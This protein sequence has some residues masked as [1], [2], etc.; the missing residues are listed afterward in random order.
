VHR[1]L[2]RAGRERMSGTS[3]AVRAYKALPINHTLP[4]TPP[5]L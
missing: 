4:K 3:S 2:L 5:H 1:L